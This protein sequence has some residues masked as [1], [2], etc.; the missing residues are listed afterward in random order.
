MDI[1]CVDAM[2]K[3]PSFN[4]FLL[5]SSQLVSMSF[6]EFF[7]LFFGMVSVPGGN[8]TNSLLVFGGL[9]LF[10]GFVSYKDAPSSGFKAIFIPSFTP[11]YVK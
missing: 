3:S 2:T 8:G 9:F 4:A 6:E 1:N 7:V 5:I 11:P 10:H